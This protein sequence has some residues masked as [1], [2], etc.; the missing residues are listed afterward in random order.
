MVDIRAR[1]DLS[2]DEKDYLVRQVEERITA[3]PE[4]EFLYAKTADVRGTQDQIGAL[5]LNYID[6][7][8][9][10]PS[11]EIL[12]DIR[13]RVSDLAG[14][15]IETRNPDSGPPQ[16]KPIFIEFSS[17]DGAAVTDSIAHVRSVLDQHPAV[18]NIEDGR[19]L[20]RRRTQRIEPLEQ[21][22]PAQDLNEEHGPAC[23]GQ[24]VS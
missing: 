20:P 1:G 8:K 19:P 22:H 18:T 9:R 23:R 12:A 17:R 14:I 13:Q 10:R 2:I 24:G 6:W 11:N 15:A 7:D 21:G 3:M 5:T 4:I 16:G